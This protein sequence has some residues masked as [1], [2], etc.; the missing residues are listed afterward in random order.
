MIDTG[1]QGK[2]A[3]VTG[4]NNPLGIG[5]AVA[6]GFAAQG[7]NLFITYL[8]QP[9]EEFGISADE[10]RSAS[11]PGEAL[12]RR[13]NA[14]PANDV[15]RSLRSLGARVGMLEVDL[16]EPANIPL[17]FDAV[18]RELGPIDILVNNAA[19]CRSDTLL[20]QSEIAADDRSSG[21]MAVH[22]LTAE[23]HDRHFA[24]NSRAV[25]LMM[26]EYA[27]R[28]IERGR[29]WGRIINVSTDGA[30]CFPAE[31]SYGASKYALESYSRSAAIEFARYGITVNVVSLAAVQTGWIG[32]ELQARIERE[33]P[34]GR[35][36]APEDVADVV[37][38]FAS[39]RARW[40]T[41][42]VLYVGGGHEI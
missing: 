22:T 20:S 11:E 6:R 16:A 10:A 24:V 36:G 21:G 38:F 40:I 3:L 26:A 19:Y 33:N 1:L 12:Y 31:V 29:R 23:S 15:V 17:L 35:V 32:P 7:A 42:Q 30:R 28:H 5:A 25:A 2:I 8:R 39:E 34:M 37:V 13:Q 41:G 9:P 27:R 4:A 18:E 14:L